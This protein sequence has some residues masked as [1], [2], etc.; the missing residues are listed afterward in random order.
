MVIKK[1]KKK[2]TVSKTVWSWFFFELKH[3]CHI[4]RILMCF[5]SG[6][7]LPPHRALKSFNAWLAFDYPLHIKCPQE[8]LQC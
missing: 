7:S 3:E 4:T 2:K 6:G 5:A 8:G 1:K